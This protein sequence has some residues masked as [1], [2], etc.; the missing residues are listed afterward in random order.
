MSDDN[1]ALIEQITRLT[2]QI[3]HLQSIV[4]QKQSISSTMTT[5]DT[6]NSQLNPVTT[7]SVIAHNS[8]KRVLSPMSDEQCE[9][10]EMDND[11]G[12]RIVSTAQ[13]KRRAVGV[14]PSNKIQDNGLSFSNQARH[15]Q[16][17]C[18]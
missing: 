1:R 16:F 11:P 14:S 2:T 8:S 9:S 15:K 17:Q 12:T 13:R 5:Q 10:T 18:E 3:T 7:M 4:Y 6:L